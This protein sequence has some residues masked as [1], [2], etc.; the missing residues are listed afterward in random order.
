MRSSIG[1]LA[2]TIR[3]QAKNAE[4]HVSRAKWRLGYTLLHNALQVTPEHRGLLKIMDQVLPKLKDTALLLQATEPYAL[5]GFRHRNPETAKELLRLGHKRAEALWNNGRHKDAIDL[6]SSLIELD[7]SDNNLLNTV[8]YWQLCIAKT[9]NRT[10]IINDQL[11]R[12]FLEIERQQ[13]SHNFAKTHMA[14]EALIRIGLN[15]EA[16]QLLATHQDEPMSFFALANSTL[17]QEDLWLDYL[18]RFFSSQ[19]M[20]SITL[21]S[22]AGEKFYRLGSPGLEAYSGE[23]KISVIMTAFNVEKYIETAIRSMLA[24]TWQNFEL[25]IVDDVSTDSTKCIVRKLM[26]IDNRIKLIENSYNCGTYVS[27]NK[28][29]DL[30]TGEYVTCHDSDDWAHPRKIEFQIRAL[31]KNPDAVSCSSNWVRMHENGFFNFHAPGTF[32]QFNAS[33]LLFNIKQVKPFIGY[34]DSV[35]ISADTEFINRL[36]IVFGKEQTIKLDTVLMFGLKRPESLTTANITGH[37]ANGIS[38]LRKQYHESF[39]NWH[40]TLQ[41]N[42]AYLEFPIKQRRFFAPEEIVVAPTMPVGTS[43][44]DPQERVSENTMINT[45]A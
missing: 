40:K 17:N 10:A 43:D 24:Q 16:R 12:L 2:E 44:P 14:V 22:G 32:A 5:K 23:P 27:R 34:W 6:A 8:L 28:A 15:E 30:A 26:A 42:S 38:P 11:V 36:H 21:L 1:Q 29:Y 37:R 41:K 20:E 45:H 25:I 33:S 31:L 9:E 3:K 35:R 39:A 13:F 19:K 7:K 18:N 4:K